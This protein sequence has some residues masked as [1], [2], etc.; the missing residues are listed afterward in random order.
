MN[1]GSLFLCSPVLDMLRRIFFGGGLRR[2]PDS[3]YKMSGSD[4]KRRPTFVDDD[5]NSF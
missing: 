3:K 1:T 2:R 5:D 4:G